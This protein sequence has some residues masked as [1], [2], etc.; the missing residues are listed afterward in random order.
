MP[1]EQ[2]LFEIGE[3]MGEAAHVAWMERRKKE[4]GWHNPDEC[5]LRENHAKVRL[6]LIPKGG[7]QKFC[8]DC[9]PCMRPYKDLPDSEKEINRPYPQVFMKILADM[10]YV[11][12]KKP[13]DFAIDPYKAWNDLKRWLR[14]KKG[15]PVSQDEFMT[16]MVTIEQ[17]KTEE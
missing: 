3:R 10:G 9:H 2:E 4:K 15:V 12:E 1:T 17:G 14:S 11:V 7:S 6:G 5:P 16:K 8:P 13:S